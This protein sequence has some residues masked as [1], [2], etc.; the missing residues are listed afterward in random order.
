MTKAIAASY[1]V[2]T[3]Y[4]ASLTSFL[5]LAS[6]IVAGLYIFNIYELVSKTVALRQINEETVALAGKV[7]NLDVTY[8]SLA[9]RVTPEN[10]S[11]YGLKQGS[12]SEYIPRT[13]SADRVAMVSHEL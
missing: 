12:V 1:N 9:S 4:R 8:L 13:A 6:C 2:I 7:E 11:A 3:E 5:L 10:L